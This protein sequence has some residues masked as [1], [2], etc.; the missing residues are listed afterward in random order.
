MKKT[1]QFHYIDHTIETEIDEEL[2][3]ILSSINKLNLYNNLS[4][5]IKEITGNAFK[6]NIKRAYFYKKDLDI[7]SPVAYKNGM[8]TFKSEVSLM[9]PE[10]IEILKNFNYFVKID[11]DVDKEDFYISVTNNNPMLPIEKER[12]TSSF[13]NAEKFKTLEDALFKIPNEVEGAGIGIIIVILM[14]RKIGLNEKYFEFKENEGIT[15]V[16]VRIP[17]SLIGEKDEITLSEVFKK[18]IQDIPHFPQHIMELQ[19]ILSNSNSKFEDISNIIHKDPQL[20]AEILK[21]ANSSLY[22]LPKKIK[23]IEEAVRLIGFKGVRNLLFLNTANNILSNKY[24]IEIVKNIMHHSYEVAYY[25]FEICKKY[26]YKDLINEVFTVA[27]LHDLGKIIIN[28]LRKDI[29]DKIIRVCHGKGISTDILENLSSGFNHSIIG[30][31][32]AE[33]W[34]FNEDFIEAIRYHNNPLEASF[35]KQNL[36]FVVY[37][38]NVIYYYIRDEYDFNNIN[39]KV[40]LHFK[41]DKKEHFESYV[42]TIASTL[43]ERIKEMAN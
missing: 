27:I 26:H 36:V 3:R 40:L 37:L 18:E 31:R 21:T 10:C 13:I 25:A 32:L 24:K 2:K 1:L 39:Y 15:N 5:M 28:S 4:Y 43:R 35:E 30:A 7:N 8:A 14:L 16:K 34:N 20:I 19:Q 38:A 41:L 6:A 12:I 11:L 29:M 9:Q 33:K 22:M 17:I 23:S 42:D